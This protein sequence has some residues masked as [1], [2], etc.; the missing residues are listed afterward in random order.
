MYETL[1]IVL[2]EPPPFMPWGALFSLWIWLAWLVGVLA[3]LT[4]LINRRGKIN[5]LRSRRS[6]IIIY[7]AILAF[8]TIPILW[9]PRFLFWFSAEIVIV[10]A[11]FIIPG[12]GE[13]NFLKWSNRRR[14]LCGSCFIAFL[15][16]FYFF[17]LILHPIALIL[18]YY[19]LFYG[20]ALLLPSMGVGLISSTVP[21][22]VKNQYLAFIVASLLGSLAIIYTGIFPPLW[23]IWWFYWGPP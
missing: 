1:R 11:L 19:F 21:R 18:M 16:A 22:E 2:K 13:M 3:V 9:S 20:N 8:P 12:F 10:L 7:T 14:V 5:L 6:K 23:D 15:V 4:L 17:I